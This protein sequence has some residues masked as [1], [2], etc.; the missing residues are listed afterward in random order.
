[1]TTEHLEDAL[2]GDLLPTLPAAAHKALEL[3]GTTNADL[4]ELSVLIGGDE[5]I[6]AR[7]L[8]AVNTG[9]VNEEDQCTSLEEAIEKLGLNTVRLLVV[10]FSL[11]DLT[12]GVSKDLDLTEF[13][14]RCVYAASASRRLATISGSGDP[15]VAFMAGLLQDIGMLT[16]LSSLGDRYREVL[17]QAKG[18]HIDLPRVEQA[19]VGFT[20]ADAGAHLGAHWGLDTLLVAPIRLHH[21]SGTALQGCSRE[22]AVA[23]MASRMSANE[24]LKSVMAMSKALFGLSPEQTRSLMQKTARDSKGL[25]GLLHLRKKPKLKPKPVPV[26]LRQQFAQVLSQQ[27]KRAVAGDGILGLIIGEADA[28]DTLLTRFGANATRRTLAAVYERVERRSGTEPLQLP[29]GRFAVILPGATRS[30]TSAIA[31]RLRHDIAGTPFD[32]RDDEG[33]VESLSIS[34]SAGAAALEPA[35]AQRISRA[36]DLW[37]VAENALKAA[38]SAGRD[39]VRVF[40]PRVSDDRSHAA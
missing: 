34:L 10:A 15:E 16:M 36:E 8:Q 25:S 5:L 6:A 27:F 26:D 35:V 13:W 31:E 7:L 17:I 21:Q 18:S 29:G 14:R 23:A 19:A 20:H 30:D 39:C 37:R 11:V 32:V 1:M 33:K 12:R 38:V 24:D 3:V 22:V 4:G 2:P 28:M 9:R 40:T